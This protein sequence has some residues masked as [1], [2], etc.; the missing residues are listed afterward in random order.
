MQ[1]DDRIAFESHVRGE[2]AGKQAENRAAHEK[3]GR[4]EPDGQARSTQAFQKK[5]K[6]GGFDHRRQSQAPQKFD[7]RDAEHVLFEV[8]I[9]HGFI[10]LTT[11][12]PR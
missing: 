10:S 1:Q 12:A 7:A 6:K 4:D 2:I 8:F 11:K 9:D 5:L 3:K